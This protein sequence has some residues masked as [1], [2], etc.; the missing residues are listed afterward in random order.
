MLDNW[1][2]PTLLDWTAI[3]NLNENSGKPAPIPAAKPDPTPAAKP[4][5]TPKPVPENKKFR[6]MV[7]ICHLKKKDGSCAPNPTGKAAR[8]LQSRSKIRA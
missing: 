7:N 6:R 2:N 8:Q 5:P 1:K 3:A 4:D